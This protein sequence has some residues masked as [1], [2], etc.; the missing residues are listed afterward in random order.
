LLNNLERS[1]YLITLPDHNKNRP[2]TKPRPNQP[3]KQK[4]NHRGWC[5]RQR[6]TIVV[7]HRRKELTNKL[8]LIIQTKPDERLGPDLSRGRGKSIGGDLDVGEEG[9]EQRIVT[10]Q[11]LHHGSDGYQH[12]CTRVGLT[13]KAYHCKCNQEHNQE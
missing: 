1:D 9:S 3:I 5:V 4:G 7:Q 2:Q 12:T 6:T 10:L 8:E 13:K 11:S